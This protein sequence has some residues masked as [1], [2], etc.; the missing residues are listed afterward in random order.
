[1]SELVYITGHKNPDTDSIC[2][3][4]AYADLK[5]R[6]GVS[7]VPVRIGNINRESE[8]VL[9]YFG[10]DIPEYL[11]SVRTQVSDL[12]M[13]VISPVSADTSI[14]TAWSI[15]QK[16]NVKVLPIANENGRLLGMVTL[17]DITRS[18]MNTLEGNLLSASNTPL[19]NIT[20]TL[21][22]KLVAGGEEN[23]KSTG[24]VVI[25][26]IAP[27]SMEPFVEK[28]DIVL[29]GN[30]KDTQKK[31]VEFGVS[32]LVLTC[33]AH[34]DQ[35]V[36]ELAKKNGCIVMETGYDTFTAARL[37]DQSIPA[38]FIMTKKETMVCF[39]ISDYIDSIKDKMLQTRYRSYPVVDDNGFIKGFISRYHLIS[40]RR[41]RIILLDHNE[42]A[43]TIDGIEQAEI[44]EIIDHH[45]IGDIQTGYPV[46]FRNETVGSTSTLVAGM[47]FENGI[48]PPKAIAGILCAAILSDTLQ[49]KSPTNTYTDTAMAEKLAE[50]AGINIEKFSAQMFQAGSALDGMS[51][52]EI[53]KYDF[54]E[55]MAD[56]YKFGIG[57]VNSYNPQNLEK[58]RDTLLQHMQ[59]VLDSN[60]YNL[61]LLMVTDIVN[62]GSFLLFMG[63]DGTLIRKAFGVAPDQNSVY[64]KGVVS[65]KKQVVPR[66][67]NAVKA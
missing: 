59:T 8:F 52:A 60:H 15:M 12:N 14:K 44:L 22:A 18:Y 29:A 33:G 51:P 21:K 41:K 35:T 26:A 25:A 5:R 66:L 38:G 16:N 9:N 31:S 56:Q 28:G 2:A 54:K 30:R 7:A 13:D 19:R 3:T 58:I 17:S 53:L 42:K 43:Q 20:D 6:L 55:Y 57:Q 50:I 62:E 48:K 24:K 39:H 47:Y 37:I 40:Q 23:F 27:D 49:F 4:I 65:R 45:R 10:V 32:C 64:L 61:L 1:M 63:D 36:L 67:I 11:E 34:A 46:Y